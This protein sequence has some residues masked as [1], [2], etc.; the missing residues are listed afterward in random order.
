MS[1][2]A[3]SNPISAETTVARFEAV[4]DESPISVEDGIPSVTDERHSPPTESEAAL[5]Q[6]LSELSSADT[7]LRSALTAIERPSGGNDLRNTLFETGIGAWRVPLSSLLR[8]RCLDVNAGFGTRACVLAE[9]T[10]E[11]YAVDASLD[12]L[13]FLRL[14]DDYDETAPITPIHGT[15]ETLPSPAEP[16][17][18]VILDQTDRRTA[19]D[20]AESIRS[21]RPLVAPDGTLVV[22]FDGW[23]RRTGI[24]NT[25]GIGRETKPRLTELGL[26]DATV[27]RFRTF[28]EAEGFDNVALYA[29]LPDAHDPTFCFRVDDAAA[30]EQLLETELDP[31]T[32][33]EKLV[34]RLADAVNRTPILSQCYPSY[35]AVCRRSTSSDT[36]TDGLVISARTRSVLLEREHGSLNRVTKFPTRRAHEGYVTAENE[37]LDTLSDTDFEL[38]S[39]FPKGTTVTTRLG[40]ARVEA[41]VSGAPLVRRVTRDV[42]R[43]RAVLDTGFEWLTRFQS[44]YGSEPVRRTPADVVADL[45]FPEGGVDGPRVDRPITVFE[46]PVHGDFHPKNVFVD[47][48][49]ITAVIDWE[50]ASNV[51]NPMIDAGFF[52]LQTAGYAFGGLTAG[53]ESALC[54]PGPHAGTVANVLDRYGDAVGLSRRAIL[55]YLPAVW[56]HRLRMAR[57]RNA[58][59]SYTEHENRRVSDLEG[60]FERRGEIRRAFGW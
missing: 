19:D 5:R 53:I 41:P 56:V 31:T 28:L 59:L 47:D 49:A 52:V 42:D 3:A 17:D 9:I 39:T 23:L 36:G 50:L 57:A 43:F 32:A 25:L 7:D 4:F 12:A 33:R 15:V 58:T 27:G 11:V 29:L 18:T 38:A 1:S 30:T 48:G 22:L 8:G 26:R 46:T 21:T 51:G 44:V 10:D 2:D 35:L 6:L 55:T 16:F 20:L 37:V 34:R 24:T 40:S 14:R 13:R 45:S 60:L 54:T